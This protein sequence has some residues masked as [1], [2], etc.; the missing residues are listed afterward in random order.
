MRRRLPRR[1]TQA[2]AAA[3]DVDDRGDEDDGND[4]DGDRNPAFD[5]FDH[6]DVGALSDE[7]AAEDAAYAKGSRRASILVDGAR[8]H[9]L[10]VPEAEHGGARMLDWEEEGGE[11]LSPQANAGNG[12][13][14][15]F[16][17]SDVSELA[18]TV[19]LR[20]GR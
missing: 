13:L 20:H 12:W 1:L 9:A 5:R 15:L 8:W 11:A 3:I 10:W 2:G 4:G 18:Q 6:V 17:A 14:P 16:A 7:R 19:A